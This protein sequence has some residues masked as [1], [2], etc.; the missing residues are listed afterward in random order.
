MRDAG[1]PITLIVIGQRVVAL[2]LQI[3]S[4]Q[5]EPKTRKWFEDLNSRL[6]T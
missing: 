4:R 1:L 2:V 3:V 6:S 5:T